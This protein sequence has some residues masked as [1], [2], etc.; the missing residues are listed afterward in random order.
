MRL[1]VR[2]LLLTL[3]G[4]AAPGCSHRAAPAPPLLSER[5]QPATP[6][7]A[8]PRARPGPQYAG[9]EPRSGWTHYEQRKTLKVGQTDTAGPEPYA[10]V[11]LVEIAADRHSAVFEV[12]HLVDHRRGRVVVG[13]SFNV[14]TPVFGSKGAR[15]ESLGD[16]GATVVFHWSQG[17]GPPV[18]PG[19][20]A[21]SPRPHQGA[22]IDGRN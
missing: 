6:A 5:E 10:R 15:L 2:A 11:K 8:P 16:N 19:A 18:P 20:V 13:E 7:D 9:G 22:V 1:W 17:R 14:F 4:S 12:T 21:I 3:A